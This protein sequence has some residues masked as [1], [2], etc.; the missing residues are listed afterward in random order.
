MA[1]FSTIRVIN[2][3]S[4]ELLW[5]PKNSGKFLFIQQGKETLQ[6]ILSVVAGSA[7]R[8]AES[9]QSNFVRVLLEQWKE[10]L[11]SN[12]TKE[13]KAK[14][15]S[16]IASVVEDELV[17]L[18]KTREVMIKDIGEILVNI[19]NGDAMTQDQGKILECLE[20][21]V[22]PD[23]WN[24]HGFMCTD[25]NNWIDDFVARIVHIN[26]VIS[27]KDLGRGRLNLGLLKSPESLLAAA[28]QT[29]ARDNK[30]PTE[31]IR[32]KLEVGKNAIT[33]SSDSRRVLP[34]SVL[35]ASSERSP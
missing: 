21:S 19:E 29:A 25:L 34:S 16:L 3:E 28:K 14:P 22:V 32:M 5:L 6:H 10:K 17:S 12:A 1:N 33:S 2:H 7:S 26:N 11:E 30:W 18:R 20:R 24:A 35:G 9:K 8:K 13:F 31:Q 27:D 23:S 15:E 4:P